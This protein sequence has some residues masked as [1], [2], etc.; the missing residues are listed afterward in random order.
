MLEPHRVPRHRMVNPERDA[1]AFHEP[2]IVGEWKRPLEVQDAPD[3]LARTPHQIFVPHPAR[4]RPGDTQQ[5]EG[6]VERQ[7]LERGSPYR[8]PM[9][10][11]RTIDDLGTAH[12]PQEG[13]CDAAAVTHE[14]HHAQ[15]QPLHPSATGMPS[16]R[17]STNRRSSRRPPPDGC[18]VSRS[19]MAVYAR[20]SRT[21]WPQPR[22]QHEENV[23]IAIDAPLQG[24]DLIDADLVP[25]TEPDPADL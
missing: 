25:S 20:R 17:A 24:H 21:S 3:R 5:M 13:E 7:P 23:A 2:D 14:M 22:N 10:V 18:P 15:P 1:V 16:S 8:G 9:H 4:R 19:R 6:A 11:F 12:L